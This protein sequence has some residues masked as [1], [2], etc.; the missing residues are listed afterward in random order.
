MRDWRRFLR[1]LWVAGALSVWPTGSSAQLVVVAAPHEPARVAHAELAYSVGEGPSVTW[2]SLRLARG[3]AAVI[4]AL[5]DEAKVEAALDAWLVALEMSGSPNVLPPESAPPCRASPRYV[6]VRW[7][8]NRGE[9]PSEL[10]LRTSADVMTALEEQ[11]LSLPSELPDAARYVVW[12]WPDTDGP[13][14]TR[15][16]RV[17]GAEAPLALLPSSSFPLVVSAITLGPWRLASERTSDEL[18]VAFGADG[19]TNYLARG[20]EWL[21]RRS[22]PLLEARSHGL[23]FDWSLWGD[24]VSLRSLAASYARAAAQERADIDEAGCAEQLRALR[25]LGDG[26]LPSAPDCGDGRDL[27]LAISAA[28]PRPATLQRWLS[29]GT[30][31]FAP[32]ALRAGGEPRGPVLRARSFDAAGCGDELPPVIVVEPPPSSGAPPVDA[33]ASSGREPGGTTIVVVEDTVVI[34]T[35]SPEAGCSCSPRPDPYRDDRDRVDCSSDTSRSR[36]DDACSGDSSSSSGDDGCASDSS[37]SSSDDSCSGGSEDSSYD[38]DT[39]TGRA[40]PPAEPS[41]KVRAGL[42]TRPRRVKTSLWSLAIAALAL[43]IRRHRR[44]QI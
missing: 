29:S 21:Q 20:G 11:G 34:D 15:T 23:L 13:Q 38:G 14:T 22:E 9:P 40:A 6:P 28:A 26:E 36:S 27:V 16:L 32:E 30:R 39:C 5:P 19:E 1:K 24:A 44:R 18:H 7:P 37:G 33:G 41:S 12:S 10:E 8:R 2:L 42:T 35:A 25:D 43:P 31:G 17:V 3:P 4:A